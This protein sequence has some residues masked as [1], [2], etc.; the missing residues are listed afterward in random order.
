MSV[1]QKRVKAMVEWVIDIRKRRKIKEDGAVFV[2]L[3]RHP[4]MQSRHFLVVFE[5]P[6]GDYALLRSEFSR[7]KNVTIVRTDKAKLLKD[8]LDTVRYSGLHFHAVVLMYCF[9]GPCKIAVSRGAPYFD[10]DYV[11]DLERFIKEKQEGK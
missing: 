10:A 5:D 8:V 1:T 7:Q 2:L 4:E 3:V 6:E 11:D 9:G